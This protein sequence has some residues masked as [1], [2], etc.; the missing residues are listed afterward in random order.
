[1]TTDIELLQPS[2]NCAIC[3]DP[4]TPE[5]E[6]KFVNKKITGQEVI[7]VLN[8][9]G[10]NLGINRNTWYTHVK[11]HL[12]PD[13]AAVLSDNAHAIANLVVDKTEI[14]IKTLDTVEEKARTIAATIDANSDPNQIK[15]YIALS[16]E[17]RH[18]ITDLAK[19]QGEFSE[20]TL[21][22]T[23]NYQVQVINLTEMI[24]ADACPVCKAKFIKKLEVKKL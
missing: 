24:M 18:T 11:F 16:A 1:M 7:D 15:A 22:Q 4:R 12:K 9:K 17:L 13:V 19:L 2:R 3:K 14:L 21:N 5:L 8:E 20:V 10:N 6:L 23:N